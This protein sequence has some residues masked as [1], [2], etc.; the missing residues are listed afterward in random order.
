MELLRKSLVIITVILTSYSFAQDSKVLQTAFAKSYAYEAK[1]QYD[2]AIQVLK[3]V[4]SDK[5]YSINMRMG[6]LCYL[7]KNYASSINYYKKSIDLMPA[8][9]EALWAILSPQIASEKW[10]DVEKTYLAILKLEPKNAT[11]HYK[12]GVIY[13]YRKNYTAAKKYFDVAL[14]LYPLDY[15]NLLMSAWT[16]YF[17]GKTNE[18][19]VLFNRV[20]LLYQGDASAIEGLGLIK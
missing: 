6:W 1:Y 18:A 17:L 5:A 2:E 19:K 20:L 15:N 14:N 9:A 12:L 13:Y 4:Y 16:N 8:S 11:A 3:D 7:D 10:A